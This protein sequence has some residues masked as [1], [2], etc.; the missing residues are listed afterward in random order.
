[1]PTATT[2]TD[3][4]N[5]HRLL[6]HC[7]ERLKS[8]PVDAWSAL[9]IAKFATYVQYLSRL[10]SK[11]NNNTAV[12]DYASRIAACSKAISQY[13]VV[14]VDKGIQEAGLV[15]KK[16]LEELQLLEKPEPDWLINLKRQEQE[17]AE[18]KASF[19]RNKTN[20]PK[21][22]KESEIRQRTGGK[23]D[24]TFDLEHVL[25]H[26]RQIHD[27]LTT[28]LSRMAEQL[29]K[30]SQAF[31]DTLSKD[32]IV[33]R[34]AQKAVEHNLKRMT[35]ERQRLDKH[36]SKSWKT[37]FMTFGVVLFVCIMFILVFF[38]IKF[39]PKA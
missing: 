28:D 18:K 6:I 25:Q 30:N 1:M 8:Q 32:E 3:E 12:K 22:T 19:E 16:H 10:Q 36:Y 11:I 4:I 15:K 38:T 34:D 39:L 24:E 29:K 35:T 21:E 33:L 26:H 37:S 2:T 9:E 20:T 5:L 17:K 23:R 31:G 14:Q 7:E 13:K 27:E